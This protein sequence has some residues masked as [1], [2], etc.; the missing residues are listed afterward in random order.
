MYTYAIANSNTAY[1]NRSP[2]PAP[3]SRLPA[4]A[5]EPVCAV[6][7]LA[8]CTVAD[9]TVAT[10]AD[11]TSLANVRCRDICGFEDLRVCDHHSQ[12]IFISLSNVN[13]RL[14]RPTH[15]HTQHTLDTPTYRHTRVGAATPQPPLTHIHTMISSTTGWVRREELS[16]QKAAHPPAHPSRGSS[17]S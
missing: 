5:P 15:A 13:H 10:P 2:C 9:I 17:R 14:P 16:L 7:V 8:H 6:A 11:T 3:G 1:R 12:Q 4:A